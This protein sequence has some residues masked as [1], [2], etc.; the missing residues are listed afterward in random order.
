M[1]VLCE[2]IEAVPGYAK[3]I[4]VVRESPHHATHPCGYS[5]SGLCGD[6]PFSFAGWTIEEA[7]TRA[8]AYVRAQEPTP[9]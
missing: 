2:L 5:V 9:A 7:A 1:E 4:S 8:L 3:R 6:A